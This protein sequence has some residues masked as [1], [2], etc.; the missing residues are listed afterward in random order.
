MPL[1]IDTQVT[2]YVTRWNLTPDGEPIATPQAALLPV[3]FR[4][5]PAMLKIA[6]EPEEQ[7]GGA[8][9]PWWNGD[10]AA[11][12]Y[13]HDGPALLMERALGQRSL[14]ETA[15][16]GRDDDACRVLCGVAAKLYAPRSAPPPPTI[17]LAHR[18][19]ELWPATDKYAGIF[20]QCAA[21]AR[22]LLAT[23]QNETVL[24]G[25]LHHGNVLDFGERGWLA[26]DPKALRGERGFEYANI[27][28]NPDVETAQSPDGLA[29]RAAII[30]EAAGLDRTRLLQ[31]VLAYSGLSA[32][33]SLSDKQSAAPALAI[34]SLAAAE[35]R[36]YGV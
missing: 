8:L 14:A 18:F 27:F 25:D 30:A 19:E 11:R 21:T 34:A 2:E 12:V 17:S 7:F 15:R 10:G 3:Q 32:A 16:S 36:S 1:S 35:L 22:L 23:P 6:T 20:T 5:L 26:I 29:R 9:L 4:G 28:L 24:H 33:W 31:W 13:A